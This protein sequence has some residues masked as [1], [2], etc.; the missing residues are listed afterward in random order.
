M[1]GQAPVIETERLILREFRV[2][3]LDDSAAL[4][5]D[6]EVTRF[7]G[8]RPQT[9]EEVWPRILR[10]IGHWAALGYGFWVIEEKATGRYLGEIGLADFKRA[11]EPSFGDSP[12]AGWALSPA[13]HGKG[14][15][16]E[17]LTA[18]L[19]WGDAR[20]GAGART[21]CM[22]SIDNAASV[23]V[24]EKAGFSPFAY[25]SYRDDPVILFERTA[26]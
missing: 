14:Y 7:I 5:G 1:P 11:L 10:Y 26:A 21:V 20:F 17:A 9:R 6:Q 22:I 16:S 23:K 18:V 24:A 2:S 15:A 25:A 4:W 19:A 3:D 12:E 8:G 13:A